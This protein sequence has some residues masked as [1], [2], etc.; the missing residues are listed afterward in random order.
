DVVDRPRVEVEM[1][2]EVFH[3]HRG[4]LDVPAGP[5]LAPRRRPGWLPRLRRLPQSEVLDVLLLVLV[6]GHA[7]PAA[8]LLEVDPGELSVV[9][10]RGD[11]EVN[12]PLRLVRVA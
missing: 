11:P 7:V 5:A 2:P 8:R 1:F 9:G 10:E 4:A 3:A 12:R 6:V